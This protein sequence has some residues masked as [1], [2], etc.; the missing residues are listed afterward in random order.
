MKICKKEIEATVSTSK[1]FTELSQEESETPAFSY[2][3]QN[4]LQTDEERNSS[5]S[6]KLKKFSKPIETTE[7]QKERKKQNQIVRNRDCFFTL[8]QRRRD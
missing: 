7:Q 5:C 8:S 2:S 1:L 3:E 4:Q 6:P